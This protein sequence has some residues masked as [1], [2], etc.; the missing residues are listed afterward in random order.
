VIGGITGDS[1]VIGDT[2]RGLDNARR[3]MHYRDSGTHGATNPRGNTMLRSDNYG[4]FNYHCNTCSMTGVDYTRERDAV[5]A[6]IEHE[7]NN[8][9]V[10]WSN[11][12]AG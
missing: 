5:A 8:T 1:R 4:E 7:H 2:H 9:I 3:I 10:Y 11:A 12:Y 6:A